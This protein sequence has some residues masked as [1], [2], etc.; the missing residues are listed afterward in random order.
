MEDVHRRTAIGLLSGAKKWSQEV[1]ED[2]CKI[3]E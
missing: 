3:N 2:I 1:Y